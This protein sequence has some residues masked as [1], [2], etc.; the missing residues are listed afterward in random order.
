MSTPCAHTETPRLG[1]TSTASLF[2]HEVG[3]VALLRLG[4]PWDEAQQHAILAKL[5][6]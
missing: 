6:L 1:S 2:G 5:G 4:V 3:H